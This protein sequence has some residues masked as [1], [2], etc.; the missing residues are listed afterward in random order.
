VP[1]L[2]VLLL[3][4]AEL[5]LFLLPGLATVAIAARKRA[6]AAPL[7]LIAAVVVSAALG[8]IAFWVY[9][10]NKGAG[11]TFSWVV[12]AASLVL[13]FPGLRQKRT[14]GLLCSD[15]VTPL[16]YALLLGLFYLSLLYLFLNPLKAGVDVANVRFF[17]ETRPGDNLIP[18]I[19]AQRIY[20]RAPIRPFCCGDWLSSDR[21][22][23]QAGIFLLQRP[24]RVAG[25]TG[26]Q[27]QILGT[28]LQCFW[29]C[30]VWVLLRVLG[31]SERRTAQALG[32]LAFAG[33]LFYNSVYV[34]PKLLA[35]TFVL[36]VIAIVGRA[37]LEHRPLGRLELFLAAASF[38]L[39]LLAHPGSIFTAP[40]IGLVWISR[41]I[42]TAL[43][44]A[45]VPAAILVVAFVP[46]T[47]YQ[48]LYDPPGNRLLKMHLAGVR[49]PDSR[50]TWE[51]VR[52]SYTHLRVN[53]ILKNKWSNAAT[54]IAGGVTS[55]RGTRVE[56]REHIPEAIG[57]LVLGAL[58]AVL[59][60]DPKLPYA[61]TMLRLA[62]LDILVW[63][64]VLFGPAHT[65]TDCASYAD[66]LLLSLACIGFVLIIPGFAAAM[67]ALQVLNLVFVWV[68]FRP[69]LFVLPTRALVAPIL[70]W[71]M[72][73]IALLVGGA[74]FWHFATQIL[75]P[76]S[77]ATV[78]DTL[79]QKKAQ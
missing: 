25:N 28:M 5:F 19:F 68:L 40:A 33:F 56:E 45:A 4:A 3:C 70:Q 53:T 57:V 6:L 51:A 73:L 50:D 46:W 71:P 29:V 76:D 48:H 15:F 75:T 78:P 47:L 44:E 17:P 8:Y 18:F 12:L 74:L 65:V 42:S 36:F 32:L 21:P 10:V 39:A 14:V 61:A 26:L 1:A 60:R 23:L 64:L 13:L 66:I 35:A 77:A 27:Y 24:L 62:L 43:K 7:S 41:G 22:P 11:Q 16:A 30:G 58:L 59:R 69:V 34:W 20:D 31:A 37:A 63:C 67:L 49:E 2:V 9:F 72:L 38:A 55:W 52:D 79:L 54:A